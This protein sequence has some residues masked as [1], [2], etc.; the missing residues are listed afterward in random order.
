[1]VLHLFERSDFS[2]KSLSSLAIL[3]LFQYFYCMN[4]FIWGFG[5]PH[6][7]VTAAAELI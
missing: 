1:M 3:K 7:A 6:E 4:I 2:L 5:E